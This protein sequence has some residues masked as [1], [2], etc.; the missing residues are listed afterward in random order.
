MSLGTTQRL[1][2]MST[3]NLPGNLTV[4]CEAI[5]LKMW[6]LRR[7]TT[8]WQST[9]YY[10]DSFTFNILMKDTAQNLKYTALTHDFKIYRSVRKSCLEGVTK[11][12]T[13]RTTN[14]SFTLKQTVI[15]H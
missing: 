12:N 13:D 4:I 14:K 9:A 11:V 5:V 6:E 8:L 15:T 3:R 7:L 2:E 1:S 10:R